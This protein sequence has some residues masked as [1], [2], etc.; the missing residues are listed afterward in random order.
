[1]GSGSWSSSGPGEKPG[2]DTTNGTTRQIV[3]EWATA[4]GVPALFSSMQRVALRTLEA[5]VGRPGRIHFGTR[6]GPDGRTRWFA[7]WWPKEE[8]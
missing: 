4:D 6:T 8:A 5:L 1:M 7:T 2:R 3:V